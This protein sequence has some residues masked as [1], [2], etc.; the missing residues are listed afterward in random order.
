LRSGLEKAVA[1]GLPISAAQHD[2]DLAA[3]RDEP[4]FKQMLAAVAHK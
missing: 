1:A 4:R 3:V 2:P